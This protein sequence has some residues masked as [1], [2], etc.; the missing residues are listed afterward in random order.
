MPLDGSRI[1]EVLKRFDF[2]TLFIEGLGWDRHRLK[3]LS[4][5]VNGT[6]YRLEAIAEKKG[7]VAFMCEPSTAEVP[8]PDY[9]ARRKIENQVRRAA[10]EHLIIYVDRDR[11]SQIW[12]WV[13]REP[14][15]PAACREHTYHLGQPGD[16]LIQKLDAISFSLDEEDE[17]NVVVVAGRARLAFDVERVTKKFYDRFQVEHAAFLGFVHG[18]TSQG[19]REW[20]ASLMLNRLM[21]VYFIQKKGFLDRDTDYLRHHLTLI[22]A[23]RGK[24]QFLSFYRHFLLR[25]FHDGLGRSARTSEL[26]T[27]LGRVPYLDGGLFDVHELERA[28]DAIEIADEAFEA[29]FD[30]FDAYQWHLDARPL[31]SD[32][33]INPD[34]LGYIFEKYINQKQMG[35]YYTKEDITEYISR[36]TVVPFLLDAARREC[37]EAFENPDKPTVWDLLKADPDRYIYASVRHGVELPLPAEIAVGVNPPGLQNRVEVSS[38][39]SPDERGHWNRAAPSEYALQTES[40]REVVIRRSRY[41]T[42]R[43]RLVSGE[44]REVSELVSLNLDSPQFAQDA[45][46]SCE[47]PDLL[48]AFWH[49]IEDV[50]VLDPTC[51]SGA[52]LFAT[53]HVLEPLYEAC[54]DRMEAFVAEVHHPRKDGQPDPLAEFRKTL[55]IVAAHPNRR[56]FICKSIILRNLFGVDIMEEAV[57]ICK[58]RLFLELAAQVEP[59]SAHINLGIEPLP[60]IDFNIRAGNTLVGFGT[61]EDAKRSIT[62]KLDFDKA[63]ERIAVRAADLQSSFDAFRSSQVQGDGYVAKGDKAALRAK[64]GGLQ[65]ELN[66]YLAVDYGVNPSKPEEYLEWLRSHQPFHWFVEF[67]GIMDAGG[68]DVVI[69]N[70]PYVEYAQVSKTYTVREVEL[71]QLGNLH[72]MVTSVA[73]RL[74]SPDGDI[75]MIVP[76][77]L[78]STERF[79]EL[80]Q[81][82]ERRGEIWVSHYD[83]RPAKLFEGAEQRLTIFVLRSRRDSPSSRLHSTRYNRW[84]AKQRSDL[85]PCLAYTTRVGKAWRPVWP[86]LAGGQSIR[87]LERVGGQAIT[88]GRVLTGASDYRL[89]YKT[90][91]IL[92]HTTFTRQAPECFIN[93][94]R[95]AS[96]RET[97]IKVPT[98]RIQ[99]VL[100]CLLNS[101]LFFLVYQMCSNC[102]DLNPSDVQTF[103]LPSTLLEESALDQLSDE[104]HTNQQ[105]NSRFRVRNQ[106]LT[107]EVR[108]QS[109][110]PALSKPILDRIDVVLARHYGFT[111]DDLDFIVN[112]DI[113]YRLGADEADES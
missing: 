100:H 65:D 102:R 42:V 7:M 23:N 71:R 29:I 95:E 2:G 86:K 61:Y 67:Y 77:A 85:L 45:I 105:G 92:Y 80:R 9:A 113:K 53:L 72:A 37:V 63:M 11:K 44:M 69:G 33:E 68:F 99:H 52:F 103:R 47:S 94:V 83:F 49:A 50:T 16:A 64:L 36:N 38:S 97:S 15:R 112:Y 93:G 14:G 109:F 3:P 20:Y 5:S 62:S 70:P 59:D 24:G 57:E 110:S 1:R 101:S 4:I 39:P 28:N 35:A 81:E 54:L 22:Q 98:A 76:V 26:D 6:A 13:R 75:S 17:L 32:N 74:L 56:Y 10:H 87:I 104:L 19:D 84:Y 30:F 96:S 79:L 60:D 90:T 89:F 43:A 40:W 55:D 51:G 111:Q 27:L 106:K 25:L 66:R 58:L 41:D 78:P 73:L 108:L 21:F 46:E 88:V 48:R 91:G 18:I 31:R 8:M 82:M 107:G 34:V 12:Q